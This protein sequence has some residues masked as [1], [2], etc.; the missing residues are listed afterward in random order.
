MTEPK[1]KGKGGRRPKFDGDPE[2]IADVLVAAV[3]T[4]VETAAKTFGVSPRWIQS[5]QAEVDAGK[6]QDVADCC[7]RKNQRQRERSQDKLQATLDM[8]LDAMQQSLGE[9]QTLR[10]IAG[11]VKILGELGITR[12]VL[13]PGD[14]DSDNDDGKQPRAN[15]PGQG[16]AT[17]PGAARGGAP[18]ETGAGAAGGGRPPAHH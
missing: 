16:A 5:R 6:R 12:R 9:K 4:N 3:R 2:L 1:P 14:A 17:P 11:A 13:N 8:A 18:G 15:Q 10:N 7:A